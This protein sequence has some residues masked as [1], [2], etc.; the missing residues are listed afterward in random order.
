MKIK[1]IEVSVLYLLL[2]LFL[3]ATVQFL[4]RGYQF[5]VNDHS[6]EIPFIK[7]NIDNSLYPND[8]MV[9]T[10]GKFVTFYTWIP[11]IFTMIIRNM[12]VVF[13]SL[14]M[15]AFF[16]VAMMSY[17]LCLRLFNDKTSAILGL[18]LIFPQKLVLG[19]S[20]IHICSFVPSFS[21]LPIALLAIYLF[22]EERYLLSYIIIGLSFN[23]HALVSL[24]VL[25]MFLMYSVF[26]IKQIGVKRLGKSI[27][28]CLLCASPVMVWMLTISS[29]MTEEWIRLMRIRSS[30]HSFPL[31]WSTSLYLDYF[32]FIALSSLSLII[33][34]EKR[35]NRKMLL[36]SVAIAIMCGIGVVF[37]EIIPIKFVIKAQFFRS[38]NFLTLFMLFYIANYFRKSWSRS[39]IHKLAIIIS[40]LALF[41]K[42]SYF[43]YIP[44]ALILFL[45][46]E[47]VTQ[48]QLVA[49]WK[50][51]AI[52]SFLISALLLRIS[53]SHSSFPQTLSFDPITSFIRILL[54]NKWIV[55]AICTAIL[56]YIMYHNIRPDYER[57]R[58]ISIALI[59]AFIVPLMLFGVFGQFHPKNRDE[60]NWRKVQMWARDH[61][62]VSDIFITPPYLT[63]FRIFSERTI[64]GE[65]KDGTQQYFDSEYGS[66]WWERMNDLGKGKEFDKLSVERLMS[67]ADKYKSAYVVVPVNKELNL[68]MVYKNSGYKIYKF[69]R[70]SPETTT[71]KTEIDSHKRQCY[72]IGM[73]EALYHI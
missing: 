73:S 13:F 50:F 14:Q 5:G 47:L 19:G 48:K 6:I 51:M 44:L 31:S 59:T 7:K 3:F 29:P 12:E 1:R 60:S 39:F 36:F 38:T 52:L 23:Y 8:P 65:W 68:E 41:L 20:A 70:G 16:L 18:I 30:H 64:V 43:G 17:F 56:L 37:A 67:L 61:T 24:H 53:A 15:L 2:L 9:G 63:G 32:L 27:G 33:F 71:K 40:F 26:H 4:F 28:L 62:Q 72:N 21:I 49:S 11:A 55:I 54:E 66:V 46:A 42:S 34:P 22:L 45:I 35:Y 57:I 25:A 10:R 69:S 58:A